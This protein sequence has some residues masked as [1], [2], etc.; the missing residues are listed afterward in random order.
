VGE[1]QLKNKFLIILTCN[2]T[3]DF[4]GISRQGQIRMDLGILFFFDEMFLRVLK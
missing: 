3:N 4:P 2:R 1:N